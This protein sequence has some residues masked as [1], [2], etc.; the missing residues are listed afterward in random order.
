MTERARQLMA[1]G[2][3]VLMG[4]LGVGGCSGCFQ[5]YGGGDNCE[6]L[7]SVVSSELCEAHT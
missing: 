7:S 6:E 4:V 2:V 5:H 3:M 1:G